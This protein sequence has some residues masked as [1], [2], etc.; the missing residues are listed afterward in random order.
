MLVNMNIG[1]LLKF[2]RFTHQFQQIQRHI[3][4]T[5]ENRR[6]NDL[7][8]S[9]QLALIAWY[10]VSSEKLKLN[11][12]LVLKYCLVHDLVEIYAGDRNLFDETGRVGKDQ[13]EEMAALKMR[14]ILPEFSQFIKYYRLRSDPESKFVYA[15]DKIITILNI[16]SDKGRSWKKGKITLEMIIEAKKDKVSFDKTIEEIFWKLVSILEKHRKP[17]GI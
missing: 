3:F 7:E 16:Y 4:V 8:H 1:K 5:G 14:K 15:L 10:I 6:E 13:R 12:D 17:L 11:L 2:T 9:G